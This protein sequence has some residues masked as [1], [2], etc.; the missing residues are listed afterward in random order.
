MFGQAIASQ[1]VG[2]A[3]N[4]QTGSVVSVFLLGVVLFLALS[5]ARF[6]RAGGGATT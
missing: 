3:L 6:L 4:W 5:T 2:G 1:F